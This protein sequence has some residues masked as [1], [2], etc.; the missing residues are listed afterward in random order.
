MTACEDG[1]TLPEGADAE[2]QAAAALDQGAI[3]AQ[4]LVE[5]S[6]GSMPEGELP[7]GRRD[8]REPDRTRPDSLR[9][10]PD[11]LARPD[12]VRHRPEPSRRAELAIA[13]AG[14]SIE[15]AE[16]LLE[17]TEPNAEQLRHLE[18]AKG[19]LRR[20]EQA[21]EAGHPVSAIELAEAAQIAALKAVVLPRGVSDEEARAIHDL[22][23]ELLEQARAAVGGDATEIER[24]LLA[25]AHSLFEAG[26]RQLANGS[27][28]GVVAL[29][30]SAALSSFLIG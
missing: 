7:A 20:A 24:H 18:H 9:Q 2:A 29:W 8:R 3:Q 15:L 28:R 13:L 12:A 30:K 4:A 23:K 10:R 5:Q 17:G 11:S 19:F 14:E 26:S 16:R 25:L 27:V 22:A 21:L 1:P 6:L